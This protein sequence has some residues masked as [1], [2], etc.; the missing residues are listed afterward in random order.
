MDYDKDKVDY[1]VLALIYLAKLDYL[2]NSPAWKGHDW[3][4]MQRLRRKGYIAGPKHKAKSVVLTEQG[5]AEAARIFQ[6]I[7]GKTS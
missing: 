2:P 1:A 4:S 7:F 5:K 3:A 6:E